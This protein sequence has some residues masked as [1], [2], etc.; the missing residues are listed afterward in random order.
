LVGR[1]GSVLF[2][3]FA[4]SYKR[5]KER[6]VK[7][8]IRPEATTFLFDEVGRSRF[9]MYWTANPWDFKVWL[10][11]MESDDEVEILFLFD[12]L[13]RKLPCRRLIDAYA[14]TPLGVWVSIFN[15]FVG[16]CIVLV[17]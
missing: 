5:F 1:S 2:D 11:P 15:C 13:P 7:V 14:E 4:V 6:F 17:F 3:S 8:V 10:R 16:R 9:P 12:A